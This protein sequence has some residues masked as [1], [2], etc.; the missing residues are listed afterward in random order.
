MSSYMIYRYVYN[1]QTIYVG[2][3]KRKLSIR[4]YE[5]SKEDKFLPYLDECKIEYFDA[6]NRQSMDIYEKYLINEMSP[7]LNVADKENAYFNFALPYIEWIPY[8]MYRYYKNEPDKMIKSVTP[9]I[10]Q[11]TYNIQR[12]IRA[13]Q[14]RIEKCEKKLKELHS[15]LHFLAWHSIDE[16]NCDDYGNVCFKLYAQLPSKI[17]INTGEGLLEIPIYNTCYRED[18][19]TLSDITYETTM[20]NLENVF[21]Y[22]IQY[23]SFELKM[24]T[25]KVITENMFL[26]ERQIEKEQLKLETELQRNL[27]A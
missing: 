18:K 3:T 21:K 11:K 6:G 7:I 2:K 25:D 10:Q 12:S 13:C 26:R 5:H 14:N 19:N 9:K 27:G 17:T 22:G 20:K 16:F 23:L 15:L 8:E 1:D 24:A 4:I